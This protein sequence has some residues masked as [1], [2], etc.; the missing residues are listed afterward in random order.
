MLK[1]LSAPH[2]K[3]EAG[4]TWHSWDGYEWWSG[5]PN[6]VTRALTISR[7]GSSITLAAF[8]PNQLH[9]GNESRVE[10]SPEFASS[11]GSWLE[12]RSGVL[13]G[14]SRAGRWL[15]AQWNNFRALCFGRGF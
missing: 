3:I 6:D 4:I 1:I 12:S 11:L 2:C 14:S 10:I 15:H 5:D 7:I 9:S 13:R 8:A